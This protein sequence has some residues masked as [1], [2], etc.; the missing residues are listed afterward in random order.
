[1]D[2]F[3]YP[4]TVIKSKSKILKS[5][6]EGGS[7]I[8]VVRKGVENKIYKPMNLPLNLVQ[9]VHQSVDQKIKNNLKKQYDYDQGIELSSE[10]PTVSTTTVDKSE[11]EKVNLKK[12]LKSLNLYSPSSNPSNS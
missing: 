3:Y 10:E 7:I 2:K 1:M 4:G 9:I 5:K 8:K 12:N 6:I 11:S